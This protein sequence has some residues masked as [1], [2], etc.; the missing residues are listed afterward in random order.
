LLYSI[1]NSDFFVTAEHPFMTIE[2]WKSIDPK[3]TDRELPGFKAGYLSVGDTLIT[4]TGTV[5]I[6]SLEKRSSD[7]MQKLY[8]LILDGNNTYFANGY[9]VHNKT[10]ATICDLYPNDPNCIITE[11][12]TKPCNV[13]NETSCRSDSRCKRT[14]ILTSEEVMGTCQ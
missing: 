6:I 1:N 14:S 3:A 2:G 7:P 9:L 11:P 12:L 5:K 13:E 8:N 4:A 10:M